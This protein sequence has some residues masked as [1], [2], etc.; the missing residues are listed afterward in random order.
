MNGFVNETR[1]TKSVKKPKNTREPI[2]RGNDENKIPEFV[3][4]DFN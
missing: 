2:L 1:L 3:I 4:E